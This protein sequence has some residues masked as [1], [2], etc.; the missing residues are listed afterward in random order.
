MNIFSITISGC[1]LL[2]YIF[3]GRSVAYKF[4]LGW[5]ERIFFKGAKQRW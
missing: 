4:L 2:G 5:I 1:L 3:F